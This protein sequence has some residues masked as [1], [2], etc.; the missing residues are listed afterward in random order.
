MSEDEKKRDRALQRR[1]RERQEK[2]GESYQAAW[3]QLADQGTPDT[4]DVLVRYSTGL[5][6]LDTVLGGGL[7]SAAVV[8][9][10]GSSNSGRTTLTLQALK[11]G[12]QQC[13]F[14]ATEKTR[15]HTKTT[16]ERINAVS[17]QIH[18]EVERN[19]AKILEHAEKIQARMLAIDTIQQIFCEDVDGRPGDPKQLSTCVDRLIKYAKKTGTTLWL[20]GH[21][22]KAGEVAGPRAIE[23]SVDVVLHLD[24]GERF[25]GAERIVHCPS[26]NRF[27]A[28]RT[29]GHFKLTPSGFGLPDTDTPKAA[30]DVVSQLRIVLPLSTTTAIPPQQ[31]MRV[32][33][34]AAERAVDIEQIH[35]SNAGTA[36]G[37]ADWVVNDI[38]IDGRSQLALK[39]LSGALFGNGVAA[40]PRARATFSISGFD[41]V[42][43]GQEMAL[44]VTYVGE[45]PHGC[46]FFAAATGTKPPQRPTI[47]PIA[48]KT[49]LLPQAKTT[50]TARVQN[51][52][53]QVTRLE[54]ENGDTPGGAA[55]WIVGDLRING[56]SQFVHSGDV[57][58]DLFATGAIDTFI[59]LSTCEAG[60]TIEVDVI[61]IGL[62]ERG[63]VFTARF[64]G[65]VTRDDYSVPPPDLH[66]AVETSGQGPA[67]SVV[68]RCNWRAPATDNSTR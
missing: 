21:L 62:I 31:S 68:G 44:L 54:I 14:I 57:P 25:D 23:H 32:T 64:E 66:V 65:T 20:V 38:E 56:R 63:A 10:A 40:N 5:P 52:P 9:L 17:D 1:V 61:Y 6:P 22:T 34:H 11:G 27:G 51:A 30:F 4:P 43:R 59:K 48:S 35:I 39:D 50:I 37:A 60:N 55:D 36:G 28:T 41:T 46:P 3:R 33:S 42:E 49:Q 58:G 67:E 8:L 26:K 24:R 7:V 16:A 19:L 13:L 18:V 53:F 47:V 12:K 15:E 29:V 2:T 45:N